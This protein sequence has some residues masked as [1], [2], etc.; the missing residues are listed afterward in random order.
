M[1]AAPDGFGARVIARRKELGLTQTELA[2]RASREVL[3]AFINEA[4]GSRS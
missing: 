3:L 4:L 1:S 2:T